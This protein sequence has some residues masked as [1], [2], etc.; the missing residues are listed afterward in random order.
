MSRLV[1]VRRSAL[2]L[3]AAAVPLLACSALLGLD[4]LHDRAESPA[5]TVDCDA[6]PDVIGANESSTGDARVDADNDAGD[7]CEFQKVT[8]PSVTGNPDYAGW[9]MPNLGTVNVAQYTLLDGGALEGGIVHDDITKLDWERVPTPGFATVPDGAAY[10]AALSSETTLKWRLPTRIEL[11]SIQRYKNLANEMFPPPCIDDDKFDMGTDTHSP[12]YITSTAKPGGP[13][14]W[15]VYFLT[16]GASAIE[17]AA[18]AWVRCVRGAPAVPDFRVSTTCNVVRDMNT[19]LEW[20]RD[21]GRVEPNRVDND[22]GTSSINYAASYCSGLPK[23]KAVKYPLMGGGWVVPTQNE[24]YSMIDTSRT[25]P[26]LVS[27]VLFVDT[28]A[29]GR[30]ISSSFRRGDIYGA[31]QLPSGEET[32]VF[33]S[34]PAA[35]R[36]VRHF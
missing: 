10:C 6:G 31:V 22:A 18:N 5:C 9:P 26:P 32:G 7:P 29:D 14:T 34:D 30:L 3:A 20:Q 28:P 2:L 27:P 11:V 1:I 12:R 36:C 8:D 17:V 4:D 24:V 21:I 33:F 35:V 16:C 25:T 23:E 15:T 19:R 13:N